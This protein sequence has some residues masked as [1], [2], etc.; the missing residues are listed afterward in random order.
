MKKVIKNLHTLLPCDQF[1][2]TG[3]AALHYMGLVDTP[4][5]LDIILVSPTDEAKN[6]LERLQR[7]NPAKTKP[8]SGG[9]VSYIFMQDGVKVDIFIEK[10][11]IDTE[12][13]VD[14]V[15]IS[16]IDRIINQKKKTNRLKDWAQLKHLSLLFCTEADFDRY[17]YST[18]YGD[19]K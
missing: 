11:T 7:D 14:G 6:I 13:T 3:S 12:L 5:D 1:I 16:K 8:F 2:V 15:Q 19:I 10:A 17:V 18:K 4:S 9:N